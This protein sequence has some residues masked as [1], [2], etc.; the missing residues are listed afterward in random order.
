MAT[1]AVTFVQDLPGHTYLHECTLTTADHTSVPFT[2]PGASDRS[3]QFWDGTWGGATVA[4]EGSLD[5]TQTEWFGLTDAQGNAIAKTADGGDSVLE[6]C[7]WYRFRL[8][9]VGTGATVH[10][11]LFSRSTMK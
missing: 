7:L 5:R 6:N 9:T 10:C 1:P 11:R 2:L 4:I 3:V 8:T